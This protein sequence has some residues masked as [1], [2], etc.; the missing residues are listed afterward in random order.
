MPPSNVLISESSQQSEEA[1]LHGHRALTPLL[2]GAI[3]GGLV[4]LAWIVGFIIYFYKRHRREK[5]ARALGFKSHREMLDPPKKKE[6]FII[7]PDPAIVGGELEPGAKVYDDPKLH[8]SEL[9]QHARTIPMTEAEYI[10]GGSPTSKEGPERLEH[11]PEIP[12]STSAPSALPLATSP[13]SSSPTT[14]GHLPGMHHRRSSEMVIPRA[15]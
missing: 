11:V 10:S 5:R 2:S 15:S 6:A 13:E 4:G 7:P 14:N 8:G 1:S 12:H 3:S 9:P